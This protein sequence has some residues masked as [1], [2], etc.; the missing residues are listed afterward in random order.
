MLLVLVGFS[1]SGSS[2]IEVTG[3]GPDLSRRQLVV[4]DRL[5]T[6]CFCVYNT[7]IEGTL[8]I[9]KNISYI[10]FIL[11]ASFLFGGRFTIM[12]LE[13]NRP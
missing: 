6:G 5:A 2:D 9:T 13:K 7:E 11:K 10:S 1:A 12:I 3:I 4:T 8:T